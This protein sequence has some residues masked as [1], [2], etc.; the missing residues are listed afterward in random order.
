M[1]GAPHLPRLAHHRRH[2]ETTNNS[3]CEAA[4]QYLSGGQRRWDQDGGVLCSANVPR[5][6]LRPPL[7]LNFATQSTPPS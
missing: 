7:L 2:A 1:N 4:E 5:G 6:G 3:H